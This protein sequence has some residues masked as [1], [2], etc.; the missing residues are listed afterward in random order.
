MKIWLCLCN[1]NYFSYSEFCVSY[2]GDSGGP[3]F[4]FDHL[5]GDTSVSRYILFGS[6]H[7]SVESCSSRYP[8]IFV[9]IADAEILEFARNLGEKSGKTIYTAS[10]DGMTYYTILHYGNSGYGVSIFYSQN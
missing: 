9:R 2:R 3:A 4:R 8:G 5:N 1:K 7:G 6:V 10:D